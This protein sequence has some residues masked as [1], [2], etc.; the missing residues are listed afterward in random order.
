M[1]YKEEKYVLLAV[2]S[3]SGILLVEDGA[4]PVCYLRHQRKRSMYIILPGMIESHSGEITRS[5]GFWL[6]KWIGRS[7]FKQHKST[8]VIHD[9]IPPYRLELWSGPIRE[10]IV[11]GA[12]NIGENTYQ[13]QSCPSD[14]L[15][16]HETLALRSLDTVGNVDITV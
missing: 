7:V 14:A 15:E 12:Q 9:Q 4:F 16:A 1:S 13:P 5:R 2:P 8:S 6:R 11:G 3:V 10:K